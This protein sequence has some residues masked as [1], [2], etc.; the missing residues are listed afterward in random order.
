[1]T[2]HCI[3]TPS[4]ASWRYEGTW[5]SLHFLYALSVPYSSKG[6]MRDSFLLVREKLQN[7]AF[8]IDKKATL[9]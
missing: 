7:R 8:R 6:A 2:G 5:F 4:A 3:T 1:M 9:F